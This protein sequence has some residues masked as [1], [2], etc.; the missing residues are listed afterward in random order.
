M[1]SDEVPS[2]F[3]ELLQTICANWW[4]LKQTPFVWEDAHGAIVVKRP[5]NTSTQHTTACRS[6]I[7]SDVM[8]VPP[9]VRV[10][11]TSAPKQLGQSRSS[12]TCQAY[13]RRRE[14]VMW[15]AIRSLVNTPPAES[16]N[17]GSVQMGEKAGESMDEL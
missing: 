10:R 12:S 6:E 16:Q 9:C 3:D 2:F 4:K 15:H 1:R 17:I 14:Q 13:R 7:C 5:L 11:L 8:S